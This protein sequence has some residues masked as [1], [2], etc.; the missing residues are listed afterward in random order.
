MCWTLDMT[1]LKMI[2]WLRTTALCSICTRSL[3]L[4]SGQPIMICC[5]SVTSWMIKSMQSMRVLCCHCWKHLDW[6][7]L[8]F[9][10][11]YK[12][13]VSSVLNKHLTLTQDK[14]FIF[15]VIVWVGVK[16]DLKVRTDNLWEIK[17]VRLV[18]MK[19]NFN[20]ELPLGNMLFVNWIVDDQKDL[21]WV[22]FFS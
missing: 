2:G 6:S 19:T 21:S 14:M 4:K 3:R 16:K 20:T 9:N 12:I 22:T 1:I 18:R 7:M 8:V 17:N 13:T 5:K 10:F 15:V 11:G